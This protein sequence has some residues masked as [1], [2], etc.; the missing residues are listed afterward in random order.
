MNEGSYNNYLVGRSRNSSGSIITTNN[1]YHS[2]SISFISNGF[3]NK[4]ISFDKIFSNIEYRMDIYDESNQLSNKSF[5][6]ISVNNEYQDTGIVPLEN[7]KNRPSNLKKKF[8]IWRVQIPRNNKM[9]SNNRGSRDRIRNTW[10]NITLT[11]DR[12]PNK[13]V[14]HDINVFYYI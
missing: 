1:D 11:S 12:E 4:H 9:D 7:T 2:W 10:C 14:L 5:D 3:Q 6:T 8:R 13:A